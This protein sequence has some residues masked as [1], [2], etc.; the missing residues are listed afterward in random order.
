MVSVKLWNDSRLEAF[1]GSRVGVRERNRLAEGTLN[2]LLVPLD[3]NVQYEVVRVGR[4]EL[5][6]GC[7]KWKTGSHW[8]RA[9]F[10]NV[11]PNRVPV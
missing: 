3:V 11:S 10:A 8:N 5:P 4:K 7:F 2:R 1:E 9:D 6:N